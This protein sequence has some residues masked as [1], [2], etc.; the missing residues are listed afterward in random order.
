MT[1]VQQLDHI[2]TP[3]S[4]YI[5]GKRRTTM[6]AV[7][8]SVMAEQA[9]SDNLQPNAFLISERVNNGI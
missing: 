1:F 4:G 6:Y 3:N 7:V 2:A 8:R 5:V 9:R